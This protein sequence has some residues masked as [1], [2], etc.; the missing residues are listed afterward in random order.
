ML[1]FINVDKYFEKS[2]AVELLTTT[3]AAHW[4]L[5]GAAFL[6]SF[7]CSTDF[8]QNLSSCL[9]QHINFSL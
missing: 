7:C 5:G 6:W 8:L 4:A 1:H 9:D 2:A 3:W